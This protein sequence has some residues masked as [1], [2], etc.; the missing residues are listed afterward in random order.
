MQKPPLSSNGG[1]FALLSV[2]LGWLNA[3]RQPRI[4]LAAKI[5]QI[6]E[7]ALGFAQALLLVGFETAAHGG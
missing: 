6:W 7:T 4:G 5:G 2:E 1:F 3:N